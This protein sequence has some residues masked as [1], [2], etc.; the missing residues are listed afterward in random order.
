MS[1]YGQLKT[2]HEVAPVINLENR[3]FS[4][5]KGIFEYLELDDIPH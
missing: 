1:T 2:N 3:R 4:S 5:S